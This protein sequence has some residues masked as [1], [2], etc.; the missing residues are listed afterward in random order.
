MAQLQ[1]HNFRTRMTFAYMADALM[2]FDASVRCAS[3]L[4]RFTSEG[5][6]PYSY[7]WRMIEK[8]YEDMTNKDGI[9]LSE[10]SKSEFMHFCTGA[11]SSGFN[12][13]DRHISG[14]LVRAKAAQW[15]RRG[16]FRYEEK[17]DEKVK[18]ARR[19]GV[20]GGLILSSFIL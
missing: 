15:S 3:T 11:T 19:F 20:V 18:T 6:H 7:M 17:R 14:E 1:D 5:K 12:R 10:L 8:L 4:G 13:D 16:W 2:D 9:L